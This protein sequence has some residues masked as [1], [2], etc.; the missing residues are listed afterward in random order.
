LVLDHMGRVMV[1]LA[2]SIE[3]LSV[4]EIPTRAEWRAMITFGRLRC[5]GAQQTSALV[6]G[7]SGDG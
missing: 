4:S 1:I 2:I 5:A 7:R 3:C 6:A